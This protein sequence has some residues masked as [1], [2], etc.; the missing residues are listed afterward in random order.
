MREKMIDARVLLVDDDT[1]YLEIME[2]LMQPY[3]TTCTCVPNGRAGMEEIM[4]NDYDVIV[5]DF[6]MPIMNGKDFAKCAQVLSDTVQERKIPFI[7]HTA[8]LDRADENIVADVI[9]EKPTNFEKLLDT[10]KEQL[11]KRKQVA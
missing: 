2:K 9:L 4:M 6:S 8:Y 5:S 7:L 1:E 11:E 3:F 10:I